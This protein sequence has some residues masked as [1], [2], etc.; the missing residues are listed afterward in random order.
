MYAI[1]IYD[2][3]EDR[4]RIPRQFLRQYLVHVQ[5]SVFEGKITEGQLKEIKSKLEDHHNSGESIIIYTSPEHRVSR[6]VFGDDP[7]EDNSFI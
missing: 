7:T 6:T 2:C 5:N 3:K 4:T 1:V